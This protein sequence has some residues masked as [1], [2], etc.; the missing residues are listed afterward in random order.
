MTLLVVAAVTL[1]AALFLDAVSLSAA[2][3]LVFALPVLGSGL[4]ALIVFSLVV[5]AGVALLVWSGFSR[6]AAAA[7]A[8]L[9]GCW[10]A[11][12]GAIVAV[13]L[14]LRAAVATATTAGGT[15]G[16]AAAAMGIGVEG[17]E[18]VIPSGGL[19][20]LV[21]LAG[22]RFTLAGVELSTV[23]PHLSVGLGIGTVCLIGAAFACGTLAVMA[24]H[25]G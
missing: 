2:G 22:R 17:A 24:A 15:I 9:T 10:L 25:R 8:L 19:F 18:F 14:P 23:I 7:T 12:L 13:W 5:V 3:I 1:G 11:L 6:W 21:G 16:D 20:D 4:D